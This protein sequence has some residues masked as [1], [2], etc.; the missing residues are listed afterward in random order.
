MPWKETCI[1]DQRLEFIADYLKGR[2]SITRL[3]ELYGVSRPTAYKWI[4]RYDEVG[5]GGL[6]DRSKRPHGNPRAMSPFLEELVVAARLEYPSWGPKKLK[7]YLEQRYPEV[8]IPAAS[9]IGEVLKRRELIGERPRR[10]HAPPQSQPFGRCGGPNAVWCADFKGQFRLRNGQSCYPLTITDAYSRLLIRC[11]ALAH[12]S[13]ALSHP[14]FASAFAEYGL[15]A[16]IR[17]DNGQPFAS[18]AV[19]GLSRLSVWWLKL[20]I[21]PERIR[22]GHPQDNGRR[23][24]MHRTLKAETTRPPAS[25]M[26]EQQR[27]FDRFQYRFNHV[28]P[29]EALDQQPPAQLYE[30]S[31]TPYHKP[32][33]DPHYPGHY[34]LRRVKPKGSF[35]WKGSHIYASEALGGETIALHENGEGLWTVYFAHLPIASLEEGATSL[36]PL[37]KRAKL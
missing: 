1:V 16:A 27:L 37:P 26:G 8:K 20:G 19:G 21:S 35:S 30:R 33:K 34:E 3:C 2:D 23:E 29:H 10:R 9:T 15:P 6:L 36:K 13:F 18:V 25:S 22:P 5:P 32:P 4:A 17:T 28:R 12:P 31:Q 14:V 7:A 24:R 11:Q